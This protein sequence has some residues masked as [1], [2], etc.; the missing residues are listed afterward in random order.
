MNDVTGVL[1]SGEVT[2]M[3]WEQGYERCTGVVSSGEVTR[4]ACCTFGT[5]TCIFALV[6]DVNLMSTSCD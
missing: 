4:T 6:P 3:A 5:F 1:S 2:R